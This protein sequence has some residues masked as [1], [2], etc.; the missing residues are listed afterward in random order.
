M[1]RTKKHFLLYFAIFPAV[2]LLNMLFPA[3]LN[4]KLPYLH[5]IPTVTLA[6]MMLV[7]GRTLHSRIIHPQ[8][9]RCLVAVSYFLFALFVIRIARWEYFQTAVSDRLLWYLYYIP[10]I[11]VPLLS[12]HAALYLSPVKS[13][14]QTVSLRAA[15]VLSILIAAGV[16]TNDLHGWLLHFIS[17][18]ESRLTYEE[19]SNGWLYYVLFA[20]SVILSVGVVAV[21]SRNCRL[22][23]ARRLWYVPCAVPLLLLVL[24][25]LIGGS[26]KLFGVKAFYIQEFYALC[27]IGIWEG[28]ILIGLLP[29]NTGYRELFVE[30]HI[31]AV[32]KDAHD[33][34][35]YA[36]VQVQ[37][38]AD[39]ADTV[40][41]TKPL[42]SGSITW[43]EDVHTI[44]QMREKLAEANA[45][46]EE[47]NDLI[48]EENRIAAERTQYET[49]NRLYDRIALHSRK[50]L[51][52][53]AESYTD[54]DAFTA[55]LPKN[56][57]LGTYIKRSANL[58]LLADANRNLSTDELMLAI[59]ETL[60]ALRLSGV[61]CMLQNGGVR[62][63]PSG[64]LVA[65]YDLTEALAE[66]VFG[67]CSAFCASVAPD[68]DTVLLLETDTSPSDAFLQLLQTAGL[69]LTESS[70]DSGYQLR[71]GG[72]SRA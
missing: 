11:A 33:S 23:Q 34:M 22:S 50:Q 30:S 31:S 54:T 43:T 70:T 45:N 59:R 12:Y 5:D 62:E 29:S 28:C 37:S 46:L 7:W 21:L 25:N 14:V 26:P 69:N 35:W 2:A 53:I 64:L 41:Q 15:W 16:L 55:N 60:D 40:T 24:Y 63:Y 17:Y 48:E 18:S 8:T 6:V 36:S 4:Q 58:M 68:A 67:R 47:E 51:A 72:V 32:L 57:L 42:S 10:F 66:S 20:M 13:R 65:V 38:S 52:E 49:Q 61:D 27:C 44:R 1:T 71:I 19:Y 3:Q 39:P 56:L 9:R